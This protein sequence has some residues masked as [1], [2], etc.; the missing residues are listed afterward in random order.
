M[1]GL[2]LLASALIFKQDLGF[3]IVILLAIIL[4]LVVLQQIFSP[5]KALLSSIKTITI[6]LLQSSMLAII[7]FIVFPRLSP[8]WQVPNAKSA[9]TGLSDEVSP[10]DIANLALSS[11]LAFRVDFK[12][13]DRPRYSDLYWRAMTLENFDGRKW[14]RVI[15]TKKEYIYTTIICTTKRQERVFPMMLLLNQVINLGYFGLA[16]ITSTDSNLRLLDDYT[17]Q[18]R[19]PLSQISHYQLKKL[20]ASTTGFNY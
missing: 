3:S 16:I 20:L 9:Q 4:N 17:I 13:K 10:G 11:D 8:F 15:E 18:S 14:T 2:F 7:L 1:I 12:G 19:N 6:L 5:T